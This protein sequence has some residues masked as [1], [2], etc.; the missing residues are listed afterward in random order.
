[1]PVAPQSHQ[2]NVG[3]GERAISGIVGAALL[4]RAVSKPTL[5]RSVLGAAGI[6]LL[7]R[8]VTG[9]CGLYRALGIDT[10]EHDGAARRYVDH[11]RIDQAS[12]D[13]FPASD[14]PSWTPVAG[15]AR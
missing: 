2:V 5:G 1:V 8:A 6:N 7:Q 12:D 13:S 4:A 9:H 11:D 14:P 15:T 3:Y 10:A